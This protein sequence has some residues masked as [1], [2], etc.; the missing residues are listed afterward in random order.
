MQSSKDVVASRISMR[1]ECL[2]PYTFSWSES[3]SEY[4][5]RRLINVLLS[6]SIKRVY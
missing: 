2:H 1:A 5:E 3:D 6:K 4:T